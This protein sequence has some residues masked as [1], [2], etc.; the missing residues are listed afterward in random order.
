MTVA[1]LT[2]SPLVVGPTVPRTVSVSALPAPGG[3]LALLNTTFSR[4]EPLVP[5]TPAP[6]AA[7]LAVTSV[8]AAGTASET[9]KPV[10]VD[11]PALVTTI[12]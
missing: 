2:S 10:A 1:V 11:G 7:Q 5:Q 6:V 9:L 4:S 3:R 12:V 8:I